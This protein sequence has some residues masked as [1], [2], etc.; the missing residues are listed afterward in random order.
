M[1]TA[2]ITARVD[3]ETAGKIELLAKHTGRSRSW[4]AA[5]ALKSYADQE[6]LFLAFVED[7]HAAIARGEVVDDAEAQRRIA[8]LIQNIRRKK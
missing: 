2:V 4:L 5:K 8:G 6:S 1:R 3:D 7:G